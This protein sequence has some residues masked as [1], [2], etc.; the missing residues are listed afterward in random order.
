MTASL[1]VALTSGEMR[2]F[3]F[4]FECLCLCSLPMRRYVCICFLCV[5]FHVV[6]VTCLL[7]VLK[8][9]LFLK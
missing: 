7:N 2:R 8:S 9:V 3:I 1:A 4:E 6:T 5:Q